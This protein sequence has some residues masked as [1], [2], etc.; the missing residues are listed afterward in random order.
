MPGRGSTEAARIRRILGKYS[1]QTVCRQ[2]GCPNLGRCFQSGTATFLIMGKICTR[3]CFYCAIEGGG[4][5]LPPPDPEEPARVASAAKEMDL[6]FVVVTSVTRDDLPDGGAS[7]FALT[8]EALKKAIDGV[9]V[10]VLTPD[11]RGNPAS[12][13]IVVS[14]GPH[15]FNH[16]LETVE[17]LF[18]DI[19]PDANYRR[20]LAVLELYGKLSPRTPLKSGLML[21]LGET[22]EEVSKAL[23]DLRSVGVTMLTLGQYLQPSTK[24]R[25]V[26]RYLHPSEF[27]EWREMALGMG[28]E[29]VSSGPLVRSSFHAMEDYSTVFPDKNDDIAISKNGNGE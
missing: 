27:D 1:L 28:F 12:L 3:N 16:N 15:V 29:A 13:E 21:G 22:K 9:M 18:G 23:Y 8:V 14:S 24:H 7:H 25:A 26:T 4:T 17:R 11:F 19:R 2:A 5:N 20:S 10:E 6:E